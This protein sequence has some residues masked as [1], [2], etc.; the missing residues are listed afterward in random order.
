MSVKAQAG[1]AGPSRDEIAT[2]HPCIAKCAMPRVKRCT[3]RK[4]VM[5]FTV[6][7]ICSTR[8]PDDI[9]RKARETMRNR[10]WPMAA[11]KHAMTDG[12]RDAV[13]Q[14]F[15]RTMK[16]IADAS[17]WSA[18]ATIDNPAILGEIGAH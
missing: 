15:R 9:E 1:I 2:T 11:F 17:Q 6:L 14:E 4:I 5:G 13:G 18:R 3:E 16:R 12:S 7:N 8:S 10:I